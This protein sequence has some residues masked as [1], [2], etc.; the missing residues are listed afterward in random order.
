MVCFVYATTR[1]TLDSLA[2]KKEKN[3]KRLESVREKTAVFIEDTKLFAQ[4][5]LSFFCMTHNN[6]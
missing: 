1:N 2:E 6:K 3:F 4:N 5:M